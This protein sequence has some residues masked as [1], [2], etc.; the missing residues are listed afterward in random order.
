MHI[1]QKAA[2]DLLEWELSMEYKLPDE[3]TT[4]AMQVPSRLGD[5]LQPFPAK[6]AHHFMELTDSAAHTSLFPPG[7]LLNLHQI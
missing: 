7:S 6:K 5:D 4:C 1:A 2:A 3:A